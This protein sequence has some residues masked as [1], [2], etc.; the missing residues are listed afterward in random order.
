MTDLQ[1]LANY[2]A[3]V[4]KSCDFVMDNFTARQEARAQEVEALRQAKS[5]LSGAD[6]A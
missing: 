4:H 3:E 2:A 5:V 6:F 1:N